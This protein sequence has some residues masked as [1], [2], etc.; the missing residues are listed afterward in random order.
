MIELRPG[1][2]HRF[3]DAVARWVEWPGDH[4][5]VIDAAVQALVDD[6]DTPS[7]RTL[8][9]LTPDLP[10][11]EIADVVTD[12]LAELGLPQPGS[13]G[14]PPRDYSSETFGRLP[15]DTIRFAI[16]PNSSEWSHDYEL[17]V[18][19]NEVEMTSKGAGM[20]MSPFDVI[21]P[22]RLHAEPTAR[23]V[24]IARCECGEYGC[25]STD[26][27]IRREGEVVHWDW[28]IEKPASGGAT[29]DAEQYETEVDRLVNDRTWERPQDTAARAVIEG[30]DH[31]RLA[32]SNLRFLW[33]AR[34][35]KSPDVFR[36][37]LKA[38][39]DFYAYV[40]F[41]FAGRTPESVA[42]DLLQALGTAPETWT[43]TYVSS[44]LDVRGRP[45]MAGPGWRRGRP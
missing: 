44:R 1:P 37:C 12:T 20:G 33:A 27:L 8:A 28:L 41:P 14:A 36:A 3:Y 16:T 10:R 30:V 38:D 6:L 9:G 11:A 22:N 17:Q 4:R 5:I 21:L 23:Q 25:G 34:T 13:E 7:L 40:G 35:S 26:V 32:E 39:D 24:P 42:E 18:F 31:D 43:A 29:F 15:T 45:S 19:I 2:R